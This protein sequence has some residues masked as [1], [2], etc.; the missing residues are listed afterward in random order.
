MRTKRPLRG[1]FWDGLKAVP[2]RFF[3]NR[4]DARASV[5][6]ALQTVPNGGHTRRAPPLVE[7][8]KHVRFAEIDLDWPPSRALRVVAFEVPIDALERDLERHALRR[9]AC[10]Q[11][12]RRPRHSD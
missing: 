7:H 8:V 12:E 9:P 3:G 5:R 10:D 1:S 2:Y 11:I 4:I 6:D